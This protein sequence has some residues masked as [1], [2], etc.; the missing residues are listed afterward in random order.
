MNIPKNAI[1]A[2]IH[3]DIDLD[4]FPPCVTEDMQSAGTGCELFHSPHS[5]IDPLQVEAH[6]APVL[7]GTFNFLTHK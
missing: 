3:K 2:L 6:H 1:T 4:Q 5:S 7:T